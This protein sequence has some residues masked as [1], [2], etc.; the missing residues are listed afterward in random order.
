MTLLDS[1]SVVDLAK[2]LEVRRSTLSSWIHKDRRPPMGVAMKLTSLTGLSLEK[3]EYGLDWE[4]PEDDEEV[5][6]ESSPLLKTVMHMVKDL[7]TQ[8]LELL[9]TLITY[10]KNNPSAGKTKLKSRNSSSKR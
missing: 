5:A 7:D 8:E 3:L 6:E 9:K 1:P 2:L 4:P 10:L